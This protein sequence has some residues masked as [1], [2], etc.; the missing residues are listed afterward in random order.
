MTSRINARVSD[1]LAKKLARLRKKTGATTTE[2]VTA[3]LE[4]YYAQQMEP[5]SSPASLLEDFIG[6]AEGDM[7]LS[8]QYKSSL[9]ESLAKK[10]SR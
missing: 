5:S 8:R 7:E 10:A 9:T 6:S 3:S 1:E 4:A 2:I